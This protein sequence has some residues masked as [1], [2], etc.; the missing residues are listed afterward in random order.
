MHIADRSK[1][2]KIVHGDLVGGVNE[3]TL[4]FEEPAQERLP[5]VDV[6]DLHLHVVHLPLRLLRAVELAARAQV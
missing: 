1:P 5:Q 3:L 6:L 2:G 4:Y